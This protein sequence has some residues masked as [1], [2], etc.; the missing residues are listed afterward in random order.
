MREKVLPVLSFISVIV[1]S[2]QIS[3]R[4]DNFRYTEHH[5]TSNSIVIQ[6]T[7]RQFEFYESHNEKL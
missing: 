7:A 3:I 6:I 4:F 1:E 5:S 2:Y